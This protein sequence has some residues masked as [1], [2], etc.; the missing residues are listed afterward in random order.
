M[1]KSDYQGRTW[2]YCN[3]CKKHQHRALPYEEDKFYTCEDCETKVE[4]L[5]DNFEQIKKL[6]E[7]S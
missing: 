2:Q 7:E 4:Y 1:L 3:L 5:M 6:I